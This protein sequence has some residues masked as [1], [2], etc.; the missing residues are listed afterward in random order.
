MAASRLFPLHGRPSGRNG[1][2]R[3]P[4]KAGRTLPL[5]FCLTLSSHFRRS[6]CLSH[7]HSRTDSA[8]RIPV[9]KRMVSE[10]PYRSEKI[11]SVL[12]GQTLFSPENPVNE[13]DSY[14]GILAFSFA[15]RGRSPRTTT[16][17]PSRK[18]PETTTSPLSR[19][20]TTTG[21]NRGGA[22]EW[23]RKTP[24][25]PSFRRTTDPEGSR[26]S[27]FPSLERIGT[28]T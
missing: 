6:D 9:S 10:S 21:T 4:K 1:S 13:T 27:V 15:R 7:P 5:A 20:K 2:G 26:R 24:V 18:S 8:G 17:S 3:R 19:P 28:R 14:P 22:V 11:V 16:L 12:H 25:D 23:R